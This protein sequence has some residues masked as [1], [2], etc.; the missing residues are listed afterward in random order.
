MNFATLK[1]YINVFGGHVEYSE[2]SRCSKT[3]PILPGDSYSS[4]RLSQ[5]MQDFQK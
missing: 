5:A 1:A 2:L 4:M 3:C